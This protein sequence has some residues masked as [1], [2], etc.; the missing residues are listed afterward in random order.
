[1]PRFLFVYHGG[2]A[3]ES[4]EAGEAM[5]A[6]WMAWF[7]DMGDAVRDDGAPVGLSHTV[8]KDGVTEDG[9]ANPASGYTV[10]DA[11]DHAAACDMAKGC[12]MVKDGTGTVEVAEIHEM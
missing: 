8:A 7:A 6:D 1:M 10:I 11:A 4:P 2:A 5:M 9:G 12:P 3:P